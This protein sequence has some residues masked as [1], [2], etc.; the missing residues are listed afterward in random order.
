MVRM[1]TPAALKA[2]RTRLGFTQRSLAARLG[3]SRRT[4]IRYE[5]GDRPVPGP[6]KGMIEMLLLNSPAVNR[7]S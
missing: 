1:M 5:A 6:V 7:P 4:V 3:V 2:A